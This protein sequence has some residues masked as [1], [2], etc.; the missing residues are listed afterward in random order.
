MTVLIIFIL[1]IVISLFF[2]VKIVRKLYIKDLKRKG[3]YDEFYYKYQSVECPH[4]KQI[5][6][7]ET[8]WK[9]H[10]SMKR[11]IGGS[12]QAGLMKVGGS[13]TQHKLFCEECGQKRW[14]AQVNTKKEIAQL[15]FE[16]VKYMLIAL[17]GLVILANVFVRLGI[18]IWS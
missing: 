14:F 10:F 3:L 1:T 7:S 15:I 4:S 16:I 2:L 8:T 13:V 6:L 12:V 11:E 5:K 18:W 17:I 9:N